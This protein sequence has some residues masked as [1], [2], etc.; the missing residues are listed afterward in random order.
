MIVLTIKKQDMIYPGH[1]VNVKENLLFAFRKVNSPLLILLTVAINLIFSLSVTYLSHQAGYRVR[2][3]FLQFES[4]RQELFA[5]A[6]FAPIVE[7][8]VFQYFLINLTISLT[9]LVIKGGS[10]I[11]AILIPAVAFGLVHPYNYIYMANTFLT[12]LLLNTFYMIIKYRKHDAF[13]CT[14]LVHALYNLSVFTIGH[15]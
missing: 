5:V 14:V 4:I 3:N 15:I 12:G 10:T 7:T 11:L 1:L 13:T 6:I 8:F 2:T 9:K